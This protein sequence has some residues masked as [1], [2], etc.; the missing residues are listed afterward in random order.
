MLANVQLM[1]I[2]N[3]GREKLKLILMP[4]ISKLNLVNFQ[5]LIVRLLS[6]YMINY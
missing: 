4:V 5:L 1:N 3:A 6:L 2:E